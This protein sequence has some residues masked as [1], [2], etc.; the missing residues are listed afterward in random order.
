MK[1]NDSAFP[2]PEYGSL[3]LTKR[4][5]FAAMALQALVSKF[6]PMS[7]GPTITGAMEVS[8]EDAERIRKSMANGA[9]QLA[10]ILMAEL[11]KPT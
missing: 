3:G 5:Y 8:A 1:P 4:E 6:Q 9:V 11:S 10:D 2:N 7:I